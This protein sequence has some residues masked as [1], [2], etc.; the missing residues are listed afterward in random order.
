M[1]NKPNILIVGYYNR[2]D[3]VALFRSCLGYCNFYF[4]DYASRKEVT[5][6]F[7]QTFGKAVFWGD[8]K[9]ADD[10]LLQ[11]KP[12]KV[13][14]FFIESYFHVILNLACKEHSIPTYL[15]DHGLRDLNIN[16]RFEKHLII[17]TNKVS[18]LSHIL[19]LS[20]FGS[21]LRARL[22]LRNSISTL[23]PAKADFFRSFYKIRSSK[24]LITT[25]KEINSPLRV[26]DT[27]ISISPKV[28]EVHV[29][30]DHLPKNKKVHFIGF[31]GYD[32]L[33][34]SKPASTVKRQIIF[35]DQGLAIRGF[36]NWD[37]EN[38][39]KLVLQFANICKSAGYQLLVKLHPIQTE[40]DAQLWSS[41]QNVKVI[42]NEEL[43]LQLPYTQLIVGYY[44]TYLLPLMALPF[45]TVVTLENHP[46]GR[47]DVSKSFIDAG[48]AEPIYDLEELHS[49]LQNIEA[50]H[51]KQLPHK[52]KFIQEWMYKFDGKAGERLRDILLSDDL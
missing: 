14:F 45:T 38:Y 7:Y 9:N 47:I 46:M 36:F 21:R 37:K 50:L 19:K 49:I 28:Y 18:A 12:H 10:L 42:D 17:Q 41:V 30:Y 51:Q 5:S 11:I 52:E 24:G 40:T 29:H 22:F 26:A 48:V 23:P 35:L 3:Y 13:I 16:F 15:M 8:F 2:K 6:N 44:S 39:R 4:I 31:P 20:Q 32:H 27:Y 43:I 25:L 1:I 33:A 34:E